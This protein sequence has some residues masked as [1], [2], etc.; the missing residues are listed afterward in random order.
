MFHPQAALLFEL[1]L[2]LALGWSEIEHP[3]AEEEC[4]LGEEYKM[5]SVVLVPMTL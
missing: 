1:I 4:G 2:D 3:L 5:V